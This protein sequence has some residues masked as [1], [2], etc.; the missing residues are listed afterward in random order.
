MAPQKW[1]DLSFGSCSGRGAYS[2]YERL[3]RI[4]WAAEAGS[5]LTDTTYIHNKSVTHMHTLILCL[6]D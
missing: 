3:F 5:E 1:S 4:S 2:R 6:L